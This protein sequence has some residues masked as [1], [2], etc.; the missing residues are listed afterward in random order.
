MVL[1]DGHVH[2][3]AGFELPTLFDAALKNFEAAARKLNHGGDFIG[4]LLLTESHGVHRFAEIASYVNRPPSDTP[5]PNHK[6]K[7]FSTEEANSLRVVH[8]DGNQL[9]VV[10]GRQ[11]VTTERLEVLALGVVEEIEDGRP[12]HTVLE[13]VASQG[14]IPVIP[15]GVG[16]W[17]GARAQ[18]I[19]DLIANP[20]GRKFFLGD[21]GNRPFFWQY[22]AIFK[23]AEKQGIFN[24]PG[25]D[26]L[27][28]PPEVY[29]AGSYGFLLPGK[30][31]PNTP[32]ADISRQILT[33]ETP[34]TTYGKLERPLRFLKNQ[35]AMQ[36]VKQRR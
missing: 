8:A 25:S 1:I 2:I 13:W 30:I 14:G 5:F 23:T 34:F 22:P 31:N 10:A 33:T 17:M 3:H 11:V 12:I 29:R 15:W 35:A 9:V 32:M 24:L 36:L 18:V 16:K 7:I 28:F 21:N 19:A 6:W 20:R 26:P 27:P 4:V